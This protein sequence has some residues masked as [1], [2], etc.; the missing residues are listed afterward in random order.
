MIVDDVT[1][2]I[3]TKHLHDAPMFCRKLIE[4]ILNSCDIQVSQTLLHLV[5][6]LQVCGA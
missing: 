1:V 5:A 2:K 4:Q 6:V 3:S